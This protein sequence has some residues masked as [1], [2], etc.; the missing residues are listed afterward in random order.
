M[1]SG[2]PE[3]RE[4]VVD[5]SSASWEEAADQEVR[6]QYRK[7]RW[8]CMWH[9]RMWRHSWPRAAAEIDP[10]NMLVFSKFPGVK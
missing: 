6:A 10:K 2:V 5:L 1:G 7:V 4:E 3:A 9:L 8:V